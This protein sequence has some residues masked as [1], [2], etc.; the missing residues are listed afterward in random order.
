MMD[1]TGGAHRFQIITNV[2][3][4]PPDV[5]WLKPR[6]TLRLE[7]RDCNNCKSWALFCYVHTFINH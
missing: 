1:P 4:D 5:T 3:F 6:Q 2:Y 7:Y